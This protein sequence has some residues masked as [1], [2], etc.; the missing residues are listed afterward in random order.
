M[1]KTCMDFSYLIYILYLQ[2]NME[3]NSSHPHITLNE[4]FRKKVRMRRK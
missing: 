3:L 2:E 4:M 1:K